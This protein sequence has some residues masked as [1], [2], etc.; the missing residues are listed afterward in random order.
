M[1][2]KVI[3]SIGL[4]SILGF[5]FYPRDSGQKAPMVGYESEWISTQQTLENEPLHGAK[6]RKN[7][8]VVG[9]YDLRYI[10]KVD[11]AG[12]GFSQNPKNYDVLSS[13]VKD[14]QKYARLTS[15]DEHYPVISLLH[16]EARWI[17]VVINDWPRTRPSIKSVR[18]SARYSRH[19]PIKNIRTRYNPNEAYRLIDGLKKGDAAKWLGGKRVEKEV[20]KDD[21]K[22]KE[23]TYESPG[24]GGVDVT[25]DLGISKRIYGIAVTT[26]GE[27][28]NLKQYE[29]ATSA[30]RRS[31]QKVYTSGQL[32]NKT[33][34]DSHMFTNNVQ[35]RYIQLRVPS[36][37]WYGNYPEIREV[38]IY[39][40]EYRPSTYDARSE[41]RRGGKECRSR[42]SPYH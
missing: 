41:E 35:A 1:D 6:L 39:V 38:E 16:K 19:S 9:T 27:E 15:K 20:K 31:F 4:V 21:K 23:I 25:F 17:Q 18:I 10:Y 34:T 7:N 22:V 37:A 2:L 40:D 33:V 11:R 8:P 24:R 30:D 32:E 12:I 28:N 3:I 13:T 36:G 42:W 29:I 26:G 14:A 5:L